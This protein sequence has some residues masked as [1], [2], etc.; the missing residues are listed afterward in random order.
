MASVRMVDIEKR[1]GRAEPNAVDHVSLTIEDGEFFVLLG[2]SGCGKSTLLHLIAGLEEITA[3]ELWLGD[4]LSNYDLAGERDAAMVFQS[5]A[6]YP[7]MSVRR[8]IEFPLR[9]GKVDRATRAATA[10]AVADDLGLSDL[11]E[12]KVSELSGGQRQRVAL[13][14]ALVRE[15]AVL[16]MDEPLSNLDALLRVQTREQLLALHRRLPTTTV[17]VTHDQVEAMTMGDRIAVLD[18]GRVIQVGSPSEIYE[19]PETKFVAGFIGSPPMNFV[20]GRFHRGRREVFESKGLTVDVTAVFPNDGDSGPGRVADVTLGVRPE[21]L[22]LRIGAGPWSV[23]LIEDLGADKI[24]MLAC[25]DTRIR[26]RLRRGERVAV[27]DAAT[28]EPA[29]NAV[30]LF[31]RTGE[32]FRV[33]AS[34]RPRTPLGTSPH[35]D[36]E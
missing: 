33:P 17:Y 20:E 6:L 8:N 31:H 15:P 34:P 1:Y 25:D 11:L 26:V 28:I 10:R 36:V 14:R 27:G 18:K 13:G 5:Y 22:T 12:R 29:A 2:P 32:R 9:M 21:D 3:G 23:D 4:R 24:V 30:H 16:L 19:R 35:H 7:H